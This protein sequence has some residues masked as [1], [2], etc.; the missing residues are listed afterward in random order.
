MSTTM[1]SQTS[2]Q[3]NIVIRTHDGIS[4][5][6]FLLGQHEA[7]HG[8]DLTAIEVASVSLGDAAAQ[9]VPP[10]AQEAVFAP[11]V[12]APAVFERESKAPQL[13]GLLKKYNPD[14]WEKSTLKYR[15]PTYQRINNKNKKWKQDLVVSI[16][17]GMSI[18]TITLSSHTEQRGLTSFFT[19]FNIQ[20]GQTRLDALK[21]FS[22]GIFALSDGRKYGDLDEGERER[23]DSYEI[24]AEILS[25]GYSEMSD[26]KYTKMLIE[27][28][29]LLNLSAS[30]LSCSDQFWAYCS[31][32]P[33]VDTSLALYRKYTTEFKKYISPSGISHDIDN[34]RQNL[35]IWVGIVSGLL[36]GSE[37]V[38]TNYRSKIQYLEKE[39][40]I[41]MIRECETDLDL[42]FETIKKAFVVMPLKKNER[43][44]KFKSL[45]K[46]LGLM[47]VDINCPTAAAANLY[48]QHLNFENLWIK[49]I[50]VWRNDWQKIFHR[51]IFAELGDGAARNSLKK[52]LVEK[53]KL[54][55]KWYKDLPPTQ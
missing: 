30:T 43:T 52:D 21:K 49:Y 41:D 48:E 11:A 23:F 3:T 20:N 13:S 17:R 12:F 26:C 36:Y 45:P 15:K 50:N 7:T 19:Y 14:V 53:T 27:N 32:S 46:C 22:M 25:K 34:Q 39:I 38:N 44:S 35:A 54:V 6:D 9:V 4:D 31:L 5:D 33:L 42:I 47:I 55:R 2:S 28:F 24:H 18:G 37:L 8:D 51:T 10:V 29:R 1:L 40:S 16:I